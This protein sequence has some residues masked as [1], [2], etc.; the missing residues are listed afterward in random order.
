MAGDRRRACGAASADAGRV[1]NR[2][3]LAAA[4]RRRAHAA[5]LSGRARR[6]SRLHQSRSAY[7]ADR[8]A[9]VA[10]PWQPEARHVRSDRTAVPDDPWRALGWC[11]QSPSA[12]R[13]RQPS[14]DRRRR[15]RTGAKLADARAPQGSDARLL[16]NHERA[17]GRRPGLHRGRP[18]RR[19]ARHGRERNHGPAVLARGVPGGKAR[20][21]TRHQRLAGSRGRR[22]GRSP[23]GSRSPGQPG[24]CT[25]RCRSISR[26]P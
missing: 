10:L 25:S 17:A 14:W 3:G 8:I 7:D 26:M 12:R 11:D 23:L 1:R 19:A 21:P 5:E 9:G 24:T 15:V 16:P 6:R 4:R 18:C 13:P 20:A 22:Q 2:A